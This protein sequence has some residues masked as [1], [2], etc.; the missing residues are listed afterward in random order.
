MITVVVVLALG[1]ELSTPSKVEV[2]IV[3]WTATGIIKLGL[4]ENARRALSFII[5]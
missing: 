2:L 4:V 1:D 5:R 3:S